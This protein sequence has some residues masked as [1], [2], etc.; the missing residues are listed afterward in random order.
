MGNAF[1]TSRR[2]EFRD[3]DAAGIAHFSVFFI[4]MEQAEHAALRSID[5][6]VMPQHDENAVSWPRVSATCDYRNPIQFEE[7]V[8]IEVTV[9]KLGTRS[10]TYDFQFRS[11]DREIAKG[12]IT[13]VCCQLQ[14]GHWCSTQIPADLRSRL[15][16]LKT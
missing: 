15:E 8:D 1:V 10:V 13:T 14:N 3:T 12:Q 9:L 6:S 4:W 11:N 7:L 2:V 5:M 16:K